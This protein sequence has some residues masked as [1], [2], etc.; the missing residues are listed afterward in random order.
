MKIISVV[1]Q[2]GGVGKTTTVYN[3][4]ACLAKLGH[5]VLIVDLDSQG[6]V[7]TGLGLK[8]RENIVGSFELLT[9]NEEY[10]D[11]CLETKFE[12]LFLVPASMDLVTADKVLQGIDNSE[13]NLK[14]SLSKYKDKYDYI[15]LDCPPSLGI[16]T[17][18]ALVASHEILVPLQSEFYALEGIGHLLKTVEVIKNNFN[19][20]L[21]IKG[22]VIT[23]FDKR[24]N[25]SI[26][27][28]NDVKKHLNNILFETI[29]PRNVRIAESPSHSLP[30]IYYEENSVGSKAY[31]EMTKEYLER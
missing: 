16:I 9:C 20:S 2:K 17:V 31:M 28:L 6:N 24:N 19:N 10:G 13:Y 26:D 14:K 21:V 15:L 30:I 4:G 29:I 23:M 27:V 22:I 3:F 25:L 8:D 11:V 12:N 7:S 5:K 1:N 18:N